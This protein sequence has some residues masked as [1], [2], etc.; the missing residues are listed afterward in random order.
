[1]NLIILLIHFKF[2]L[3]LFFTF[4]YYFLFRLRTPHSAL[5]TPHSA[6]RTPHSASALR[7][8]HSAFSEQ[9][10]VTAKP[11]MGSDPANSNALNGPMNVLGTIETVPAGSLPPVNC[12]RKGSTII[13]N[14]VDVLFFSKKNDIVPNPSENSQ[15]SSRTSE[16]AW[17]RA[18]D[19]KSRARSRVQVPL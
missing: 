5:R 12:D 16:A 11:L 19:L 2:F 3:F 8:P 10:S 6:L 1:M 17:R 7:T 9:P 13:S 14:H 18:L 4:F 15:G